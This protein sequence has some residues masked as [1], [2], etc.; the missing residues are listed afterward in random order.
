MIFIGRVKVTKNVL[1][2]GDI[3]IRDQMFLLEILTIF[4][5]HEDQT[6]FNFVFLFD[7]LVSHTINYLTL[8]YY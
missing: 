7:L 1:N 3:V 4:S 6:Y 5:R 2:Y 8:I